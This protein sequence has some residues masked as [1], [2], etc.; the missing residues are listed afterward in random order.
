ME[1]QSN[2]TKI[3]PLTETLKLIGDSATL[4]IIKALENGP[5][6]YNEI[7]DYVNIVCEA[8]LSERLKKL[9]SLGLIK[10]HQ[11]ECIPPKVE[12]T[13]SS[14]AKPLLKVISELE[15]FGKNYFV[16]K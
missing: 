2:K 7:H 11:F 16:S 3:C 5:R 4:L 9:Q 12:Y 10:R 14:Q 1:T 8:T 13:L 6:R 15:K